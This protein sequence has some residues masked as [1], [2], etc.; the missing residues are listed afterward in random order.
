MVFGSINDGANTIGTGYTNVNSVNVLNTGV[1]PSNIYLSGTSWTYSTYTFGAQNT[2]WSSGGNAIQATNS[3]WSP[4]STWVA[5]GNVE[6]RLASS[7]T[8]T[9]IYVSNT[10]GQNTIA[11]GVAVPSTAT[12]GGYSQ[13]VSFTNSC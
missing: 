5:V 7:S 10:V 1:T 3:Q 6:V 9:L 4:Q 8:D 12:S 11:F 2:I 13:T